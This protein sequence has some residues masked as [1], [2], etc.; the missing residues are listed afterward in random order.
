MASVCVCRLRDSREAEVGLL[1]V[2]ANPDVVT[3]NNDERLI[4]DDAG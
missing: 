2:R 1:L 3:G 4:N